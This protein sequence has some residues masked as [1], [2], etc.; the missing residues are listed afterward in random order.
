VADARRR[1]WGLVR[2]DPSQVVYGIM[3]LSK[4]GDYIKR[5]EVLRVLKDFRR[6]I[7]KEAS[8]AAEGAQLEPGMR[9]GTDAMEQF[10]YGKRRAAAAIEDLK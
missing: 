5:E 6:Q 1:I 4:K 8:V 3:S 10:N 9:W 7:L 2:Y